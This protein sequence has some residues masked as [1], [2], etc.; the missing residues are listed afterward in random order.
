MQVDTMLGRAA[1]PDG[2]VTRRLRKRTR[3]RLRVREAEGDVL[4]PALYATASKR[5]FFT[6]QATTEYRDTTRLTAFF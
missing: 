5:R 3:N 1:P 2:Q 6:P 4:S